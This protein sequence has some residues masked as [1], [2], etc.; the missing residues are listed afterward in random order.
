MD[1]V[2]HGIWQYKASWRSPVGRAALSGPLLVL[3]LVFAAVAT[4]RYFVFG[5]GAVACA[6]LVWLVARPLF[7]GEWVVRI[8]R[9]GISGSALNNRTIPWRDIAEVDVQPTP[10][11]Q[12]IVLTLRRGATESL[13]KTRRWFGAGELRRSIPL[14]A[15]RK[16]DVPQTIDA[17]HES[18]EA[19]AEAQVV[20]ASAEA[21]DREARQEDAFVQDLTHTTGTVWAL[22]L[23]IVLN[24]GVWLLNVRG[25]VSPLS[26]TAADLFHLGANSAWAVVRD[27]EYSRLLASTFLHSGIY[28]LAVNMVGLWGAGR[29]LARFYGNA[30]FLLVY[31][32]SAIVGSAANVHFGSQ[33]AAVAVGASGAVFGVLGALVTTLCLKREM[34]P[35]A[36]GARLLVPQGVFLVGI[37]VYAFTR[38]NVDNA[39]HGGGL[40]AGVVMAFLLPM[41]VDKARSRPVRG[42]VAVA[43][44]ALATVLLLSTTRPP[45]VDHRALFA[46]DEQLQR[47]LPK[48]QAAHAALARDAKSSRSAGMS[49]AQFAQAVESV[50]LPALRSAGSELAAVP[51]VEGDPGADMRDDMQQLTEKTIELLELEQQARESYLPLAAQAR[52][53]LLAHDIAL[54]VQRMQERA[55]AQAK[56]RR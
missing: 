39:A 29:L 48:L 51:R 4:R 10:G 11:G 32:G 27:H 30:Q 18:F 23:V 20:A 53:I 14:S 37:V 50:H 35:K 28:H 38:Q 22:Y 25:G 46:A 26:P 52:M 12:V 15:L 41:A 55:T 6:W 44:V 17:L 49:R 5:G 16:R 24:V 43:F 34:F 8:S 21:K 42:M 2:P 36:L 56:R 54:I 33:A 1:S 19:H 45:R 3:G 47:V 31:L 40:L 13:A 7:S 9:H